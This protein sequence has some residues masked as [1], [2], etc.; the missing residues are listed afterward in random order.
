M[1]RLP[2][3]DNFFN[4]DRLSNSD[5]IHNSDRFI[6]S[7]NFS[8]VAVGNPETHFDSE[9]SK[10][11]S[12]SVTKSDIIDLTGPDYSKIEQIMNERSMMQ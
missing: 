9:D 5:N 4:L 10:N 2:I 6:H 8:N 7:S 12:H 11:S 1:D 3:S